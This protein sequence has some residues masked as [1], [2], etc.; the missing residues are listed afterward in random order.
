MR[1]E[2]VEWRESKGLTPEQLAHQLDVSVRTIY[3]M[4]SGRTA[5]RMAL[6]AKLARI[7]GRSLDDVSRAI[8]G[9]PNGHV[10]RKTL[11]LFASLEQG[12]T[13]LHTYQP[14][15]LPGLLQTAEYAAEVESVGPDPA[16]PDEIARRVSHR[17]MRQRVLDRLRL[18]A[19]VDASVLLRDTGGQ[20]VMAPQL[21]H[22]RML[23]ERRPNVQVRVVPLDKR[24]HAAGTGSFTLFT[25]E[26]EDAPYVV[27]TE[28]LRGPSY[29]EDPRLIVEYQRLFSHLWEESD[30]VAKVQL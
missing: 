29:D 28:N 6:R 20:A 24:A 23:C 1:R 8:R 30:A 9:T 17:M 3:R 12:A 14:I 10:V 15:S 19:L 25:G 13:E 2:L 16:E 11:R 22:L 26:D 7:Y 5:P 4:E 27:A 18:F 21:D